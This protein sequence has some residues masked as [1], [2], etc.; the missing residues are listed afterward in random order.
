MIPDYVLC[1]DCE[2]PCYVFEWKEGKVVEAVCEACGNEDPA[3][4][5]TEDE[6]DSYASDVGWRGTKIR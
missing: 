5:M 2:T 3:T 6:F 4:F 1:A